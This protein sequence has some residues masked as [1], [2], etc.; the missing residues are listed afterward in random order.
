MAMADAE[1]IGPPRSRARDQPWRCAPGFQFLAFRKARRDGGGQRAAG[2]VG[3][4][5]GDAS[6]ASADD[7]VAADEIVGAFGALP[8]PA[9]ISTAGQP[10]ASSPALPGF[11]GG[12]AAATGSS[13][14]AA[15]SG[16]SA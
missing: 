8:V 11:D 15:V 4:L 12:F 9:L 16:S 5:G 14:K 1:T 2:A 6:A 13:S 7:A 10:S 3:I